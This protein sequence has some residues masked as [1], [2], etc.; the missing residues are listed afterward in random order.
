MDKKWWTLLAVSIGT[1]MLLLDI[2]IVNVAL[3]DIQHGLHA[4]FSDLQWVVDAYALTLS[5]LLL[6]AGSL[7]DLF[8]RR[9]LFT[10]G[11]V[12]FTLGSL[13]CGLSDSP[14]FLIVSRSA[15]GIGGAV[16]FST[17]LALLAQA[18]RGRERGIAFG[19]WGAVTGVAVAV[20]PVLGGVI[21]TEINWRWIFLV[22][23]PIGAIGVLITAARVEE[24]K[25]QS[26]RRPDW[27]GF[28]LFTAGLV[29]LV[30]GLIRA[31]ETSWTNTGVIGCFVG[32][33]VL[34]SAFLVAER[35][36]NHPMF[37]LSL[38]RVPT[39]SGGAVAAFGMAASMFALLLYIVLYLQDALGYSALATGLRLLILSGASLATA[40]VAGRLSAHM[41]VRWL[42]GPGLVLIGVGLLLMA[43]LSASSPWTH[44][45]AG[46]VLGGLGIGMVNPPL[47]S[48][49]VGVVQPHRAG[50]AAGI[51]NTFRQTGIATGIAALGSIFATRARHDVVSGLARI[52]GL[53]TKATSVA[54]ALVKGNNPV[55][56]AGVRGPAAA[57]VAHVAKASFVNG[58]NEILLIGAVTALVSA[59]LSLALI[60]S[61]DF[62]HT[63]PVIV[64]AGAPDGAHPDGSSLVREGEPVGG[65]GVG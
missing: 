32:A 40:F 57:A 10:I 63:G 11:L 15:Q 38:F 47:A 27:A 64:G 39:F 4:S 7:A 21:T 60:R 14:L 34:L 42:I 19:V 35:V 61:R 51:N 33:V 24:S 18:F 28:V 37:D 48:T 13:L 16:M 25:E 43:G 62:V 30:Y 12:V 31:N 58:L 46:F 6:T 45:V 53:A 36:G 23:V 9:L 1:F 59:V 52:P 22:N 17:A 29:S 3:P 56:A 49:A 2:T 5:A 41:P 50:M 54:T 44:L 8:G 26:A 20:G 55:A 65:A